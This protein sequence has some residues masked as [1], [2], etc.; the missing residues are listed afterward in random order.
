MYLLIPGR[1][2]LI[3]E[4]QYKYLYRII[5]TGIENFKDVFGQPISTTDELQGIVFAI[6]SASHNGTKRNPIPFYQRALIIQE[7]S[8]QLNIPCYIYG[9]DDV[10]YTPNFS[11][12]TIKSINHQSDGI[13][14][15]SPSNSI[16]VC[17]T[18]VM[19]M[20]I[21]VVKGIRPE[22]ALLRLL[23]KKGYQTASC[24]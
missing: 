5:E 17:S 2:H 9:I 18:G 23:R 20:Y 22:E 10:G 7:L 15:L 12:H 11:K 3:T 6:T 21:D 13:I 4:F 1:H 16:V 8:N 19:D 24:N 14:N